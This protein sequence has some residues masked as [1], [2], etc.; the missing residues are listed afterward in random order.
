MGI[1]WFKRM[2]YNLTALQLLINDKCDII[3]KNYDFIEEMEEKYPNIDLDKKEQFKSINA[4][5]YNTCNVIIES[6]IL[7]Y[8]NFI[9]RS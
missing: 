5:I 9:K 2:P 7:N 1:D 8:I 3:K 4:K 6:E